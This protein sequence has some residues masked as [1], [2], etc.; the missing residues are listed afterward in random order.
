MS[1]FQLAKIIRDK[2]VKIN[3]KKDQRKKNVCV[4]VCK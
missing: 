3:L 1:N 4:C 2:I